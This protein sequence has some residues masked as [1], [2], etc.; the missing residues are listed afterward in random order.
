MEELTDR[1]LSGSRFKNVDLSGSQF[2][3]VY[4]SGAS[5]RGVYA[6]ALEVDGWFG[7]LSVNGVDVVPLVEAEL[8]RRDP[9]RVLVRPEDADGYRAA[10]AVIERR[11]QDAVERARRLPPALLH[12]RVE[13]EYSFIQT[14]RHLVFATDAWV[15]R[16]L[17]G[18]PSPYH[19]LGLPHDEMDDLPG[20]PWDRDA[21]PDLDEVLALRVDRMATVRDVIESLTDARL[22]EMT[23]PVPE[24]GY[25]ESES[26]VVRRCIGAIVSEEW[27][28]REYAERDL[29]VLERR[30]RDGD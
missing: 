8:D 2:R 12:E 10:W 3:N 11:W 5:V 1:D 27:L 9:D 20:V 24:P 29:A 23:V 13:G 6:E 30:L 18:D 16:A 15:R 28:H 26:F 14:L 17:L 7:S 4:L 25:P 19:P 22:D 21:R